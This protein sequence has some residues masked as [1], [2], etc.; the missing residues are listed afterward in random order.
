LIPL[1]KYNDF[2]QKLINVARE[3]YSNEDFD[4]ELDDT[5]YALANQTSRGEWPPEPHNQIHS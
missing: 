5:V 3:L 4:L 1:R 2:A